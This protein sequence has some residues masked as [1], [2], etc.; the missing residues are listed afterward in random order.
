MTGV[1]TCALPIC[2]PVTIPRLGIDKRAKKVEFYTVYDE[3]KEFIANDEN[4][5][6]WLKCGVKDIDTGVSMFAMLRG[7]DVIYSTAAGH[8]NILNRTM[9]WVVNNEVWDYLQLS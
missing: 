2:F 5:L 9:T 4:K 8:Q 7:Y 3:F 1:Q 6:A